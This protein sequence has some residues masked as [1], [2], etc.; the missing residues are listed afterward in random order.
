M[1]AKAR[2][3]FHILSKR[4]SVLHQTS[5]WFHGFSIAKTDIKEVLGGQD[6]AAVVY[7]LFL[8]GY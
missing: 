8:Q 3:V 6:A 1:R 5:R 7:F 2:A 4:L